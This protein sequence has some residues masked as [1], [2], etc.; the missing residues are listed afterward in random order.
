MPEPFAPAAGHET[1]QRTIDSRC[2]R[3]HLGAVARQTGGRWRPVG[4]LGVEL[5]EY[6]RLARALRLRDEPEC[7][8]H[9]LCGVEMTKGPRFGT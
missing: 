2:E 6:W 5:D 8:L 9:P 4:W 1:Y 7:V 3:R